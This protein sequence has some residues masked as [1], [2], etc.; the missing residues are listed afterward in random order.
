MG[1]KLK[2]SPLLERLEEDRAEHSR[3]SYEIKAKVDQGTSLQTEKWQGFPVITK[4]WEEAGKDSDLQPSQSNQPC[5]TLIS[6]FYLP[7]E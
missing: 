5:H 6:G 1:A 4:M 3:R 7:E 2:D